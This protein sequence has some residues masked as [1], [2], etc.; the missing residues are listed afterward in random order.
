M[1]AAKFEYETTIQHHQTDYHG[2][3]QLAQLLAM[4]IEAS[5]KQNAQLHAPD[6]TK[7]NLG[8]AITSHE[9]KFTRLPHVG[10]RVILGTQAVSY[11]HFFCYRKFW[12]RTADEMLVEVFSVFVLLDLEKRK[13]TRIKPE[14][15]TVYQAEPTKQVHRVT[16]PKTEE[17][18]AVFHKTYQPRYWDIDGNRHVN[19]VHYLEWLTDTLPVEW[20]NRY[21]PATLTLTY[22]HEVALAD[23]VTSTAK[24]AGLTT[25]HEL[26]TQAGPVACVAH[27]T[28]QERK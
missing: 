22:K 26:T 16:T 9:M 28:W 15:V 21:Q 24:V 17:P 7:L 4:M 14:L 10:E 12:C 25:S 20:L 18:T 11:N 5:S 13:L 19:N 6:V 8:W 2:T 3:V 1:A 27:I 23:E